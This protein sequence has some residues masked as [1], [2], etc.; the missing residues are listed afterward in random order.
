MQTVTSI[1]QDYQ[2]GKD[3]LDSIGLPG[4]AQQCYN[5]V[6]GDQWQGKRYAGERPPQ[7]NILMPMMKSATALVGQNALVV[8][9]TSNNY[10]RERASLLAVCDQLNDYARRQWE[11]MKLDTVM[12]EALQ[13]AYI[14]G[15]SFLYFY[16]DAAS[17]R[18]RILCQSIDTTNIMLGDEQQPDIQRQP[19]IIVVQRMNIDAAKKMA[20]ENGVPRAE[21]AK[22]L[23]DSDTGL[24][25]NGEVEVKNNSK[26]TV[27]ARLWKENGFVHI[28]RATR[29]VMIQPDTEIKNLTRY[30]IA[31]YTWNLK[32]G[33]ARG[34]GGIWEKIPNQISI[35]RALYRLEQAVKSSAYPIKA[36]RQTS[37]TR[38]QVEKLNQ[39]GA[40]IALN[41]SADAPVTNALGYIQ[42]AGISPYAVSYWQDLITLTRDL[43]GNGRNLENVNPEN[44]SAVA[45]RAALETRR[46]NVNMQ[47]ATYKQFA[48]DI[49]LIWFDMFIAYNPGGLVVY[50]E[51]ADSRG[52]YTSKI[53][54][55]KLRALNVGIRIDVVKASDTYSALKDARLK[56]LLDRNL[57]TFEEYVSALSPDSLMPK[58]A[59]REI[60]EKRRLNA[61]L[62]AEADGRGGGDGD[63]MRQMWQ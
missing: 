52:S 17:K 30:P 7:L 16:D 2:R 34:D 42:P 38:A 25:I 28:R 51:E 61:R 39:P 49:A 27:A 59:F 43:S 29:R 32:K 6:N 12:W 11:G 53:S 62:M 22:I 18:G 13:N 37:M 60:V 9:Y 15:D 1:W 41:G 46:M 56:D 20:R 14:C 54:P 58:E 40:S 8:N 5:F 63:D 33:T 55:E 50:S 45:I 44:T 31:K 4:R 36:Y 26:L 24:Q 47:V 48:E 35:N 3:Y 19:Y 10:N 21:I 23:P 57:I